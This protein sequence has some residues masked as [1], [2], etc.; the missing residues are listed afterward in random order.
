M[1]ALQQRIAA[2]SNTTANLLAQLRELDLLRERVRKAQLSVIKREPR[3]K[4]RGEEH[5][6]PA[7][8]AE[9]TER[10][11]QPRPTSRVDGRKP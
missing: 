3:P 11:R 1:S 4:R 2:V 10:P 8:L 9:L 7:S 6:Y 5:Q